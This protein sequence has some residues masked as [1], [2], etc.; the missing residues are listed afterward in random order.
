MLGRIRAS[1]PGNPRWP[2]NLHLP[3]SDL[4]VGLLQ[5]SWANKTR[6][7]SD[8]PRDGASCKV[9]GKERNCATEAA[10][11]LGMPSVVLLE[12]WAVV[13]YSTY[14]AQQPSLAPVNALRNTVHMPVALNTSRSMRSKAFV[15]NRFVHDE[16]LSLPRLDSTLCFN[17]R[18][19][20]EKC[21]NVTRMGLAP[22]QTVYTQLMRA[23][24]Q[25]VLGWGP[26][27]LF[28]P[29][30]YAHQTC[31]SLCLRL[32]ASKSRMHLDNPPRKMSLATGR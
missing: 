1:R 21:S 16:K 20:S 31:A 8:F 13:L 3:E 14:Q 12:N 25:R 22:I 17:L 15:P 2:E 5:R 6:R 9:S 23:P 28:R 19:A 11:G 26:P 30:A 4:W 18:L 7:A 29:A 24:T 32:S 10:R 27:L